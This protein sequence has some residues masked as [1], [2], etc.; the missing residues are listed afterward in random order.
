MGEPRTRMIDLAIHDVLS[1]ALHEGRK[2]EKS[3][4][5]AEKGAPKIQVHTDD[6]KKRTA[7]W[8]EQI[9]N[10]PPTEPKQNLS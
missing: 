10:P 5:V 4:R 3:S 2:G 8:R 9:A 7:Y 1:N 6:L